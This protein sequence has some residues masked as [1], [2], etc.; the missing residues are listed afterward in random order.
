MSIR[1]VEA[2]EYASQ[3]DCGWRETSPRHFPGAVL[4]IIPPWAPYETNPPLGPAIVATELRRRNIPMR[5]LDLNQIFLREFNPGPSST[6]GRILGDHDK[7]N[8]L[9]H[10]AQAHFLTLC[11]LRHLATLFPAPGINPILGLNYSFESIRLGLEKATLSGSFWPGFLQRHLF[12]RYEPPAFGALSIMGPAQFFT[13]L[14]IA[15]LAKG[16]WPETEFVAGGSHLTLLPR[17]GHS[18]NEAI[19]DISKIFRGHCE[20]AFAAYVAGRLVGT[21]NMGMQR[22]TLPPKT[23]AAKTPAFSYMPY[24]PAEQWAEYDPE[25]LT[26]P[27]QLSRGCSY[28]RCRMCTYPAVEPGHSGK[29]DWDRAVNT[30]QGLADDLATRRF[31][32][33]DSLFTAGFIRDF[34]MALLDRQ[35]D[36]QWSATTM[37]Q[38][39]LT[40]R[41]LSLA[42]RAGCRTLELGV[43]S[44]HPDCQR[45]LGKEQPLPLVERVIGHAV[46]NGIAVVVNLIYGFPQE[47]EAMAMR[48]WKWFESLCKTDSKGLITGSHN[49]LEINRKS[50]F[51]ADPGAHGFELV[52]VA[53]FAFSYQW[54][55]PRWFF[56][57]KEWLNQARADVQ[58]WPDTTGRG[59]P[60]PTH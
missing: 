18:K 23:R 48:Q 17:L 26:I 49:M 51:E 47:S 11:P 50:P 20:K 7:N 53:P 9:M 28:G 32:L 30:V 13:G 6:T 42:A 54:R 34:S 8:Q 14:V 5:V 12:Q 45:L 55:T 10:A 46:A 43:E 25:R 27:L 35:V 15:R 29:P 38:K 36:I 21:N 37:I 2:A 22:S 56:H 57:F 16:F 58:P 19:F 33:K 4:L 31:S 3:N 52:G 41:L 24:F 40:G 60:K 59:S 39:A 44:I 1:K